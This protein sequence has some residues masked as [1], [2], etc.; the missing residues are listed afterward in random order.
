[1]ND[2]PKQ[3]LI[4]EDDPLIIELLLELLKDDGYSI[5]IAQDGL[6]AFERL[7]QDRF[8]L[9]ICD[10]WIPGMSGFELLA[11]IRDLP[12]Q[13][14]III[15]TADDTPETMLKAVREQA[16]HFVSKPFKR[17]EMRALIDATLSGPPTLPIEV[18]SARPN[19]VELLVPCEVR[20]VDR[21][22]GLLYKLKADLPDDVRQSLIQAFRELLMN[23][24]EWGG[25]LDAHRKVRISYV[26]AKRMILYRIADPG[27]GFGFGQLRHAAITN[28]TD[29]PISHMKVREDLG[30]RPGGL[31][32]L[33]TQSLVDELIYNE[34]QNEV[35][36][37]KYL[38]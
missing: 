22:Q 37:I 34:K 33:M 12:E 19:W 14:Q 11:A 13:V 27:Q 18:I 16:H 10:L 9:L 26:R 23:A 36:F 20:S 30:L 6:D 24:I 8:D 21:I 29:D 25:R 2:Q 38:D 7:R 35:M 17:D 32:I 4:V 15:M 28:P 3:I 31:G 5:S 1:M